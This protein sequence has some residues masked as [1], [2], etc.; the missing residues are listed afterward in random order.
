MSVYLVTRRRRRTSPVL[1]RD[2]WE[3]GFG[4][5]T[6][7]MQYTATAF[8][9]PIRHVFR[10]MLRLNEDKVRVMDPALQTRPAEL[11]YTIHADDVSWHYLYV[12][13]ER[14]LHA[15]ARRVGRIQ[16]GH[17]RHYLAYSFF[18]LIILL[19]LIT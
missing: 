7:R 1:R 5:L 8:A 6:S 2:P 9:M 3:C 12:P 13:V 18:T 10:V 17:L 15:A 14:L 4:P 11:R 16:T 19:W